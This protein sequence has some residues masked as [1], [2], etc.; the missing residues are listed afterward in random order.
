MQI[1]LAS[2][3]QAFANTDCSGYQTSYP[4]HYC[5]CYNDVIRLTSLDGLKDLHFADSIWFKTGS[6]TFIKAGMTAYLFSESDVQVDIYQNCKTDKKLYSFT[7]PKN[8]TRD[9][10]HQSI[11][12]RLEQN[13]VAGMNTTIYVLFYPVEQGADCRLM[14]YPYNTGPNSTPEDPLPVPT[15]MT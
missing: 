12:D 9:M 13:G 3:A 6:Q 4:D 5:E 10:D 1:L 2:A 11:L 8:Q 15:G 14:C 7:V